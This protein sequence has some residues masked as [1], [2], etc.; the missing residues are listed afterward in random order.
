[1]QF[2]VLAVFQKCTV[3]TLS[4]STRSQVLGN[5]REVASNVTIVWSEFLICFSGVSGSH[6]GP[7]ACYHDQSFPGFPQCFQTNTGL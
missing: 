5:V 4:V 2:N 6:L 1:M 7:E 3:E